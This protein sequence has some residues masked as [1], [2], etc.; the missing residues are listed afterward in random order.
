MASNCAPYVYPTN[1]SPLPGCCPPAPNTDPR[2]TIP[3][4]KPMVSRSVP[5]SHSEYLRMRKASNNVPV[6]ASSSLLQTGE[7]SYTKTIWTATPVSCC[8]DPS[9]PALTGVALPAVP[10]VIQ[11]GSAPQASLTTKERG[12]I[13]ARGALSHYDTTNHTEWN[14]T[15]RAMG[16]AIATNKLGCATC[17][18]AGTTPPTVPGNPTCSGCSYSPN[19]A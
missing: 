1:S 10:A 4:Q 19:T 2:R 18:L 12:A 11:P 16:I 9:K 15:Y 7:G 6:S 17:D 13:A 14:T 5:L 3:Y 8:T